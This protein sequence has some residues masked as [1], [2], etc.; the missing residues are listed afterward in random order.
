MNGLIGMLENQK[1]NGYLILR[2]ITG[3]LLA[4][5]GYQKMFGF[6][7]DGVAGF[8]GSVGLPAAGILAILVTLLELVGG[9]AILLGVFTRLLGLWMVVQFGLIA[10]WVKPMLMGKGF[11]GDGG[12]EIDLLLFGIGILL[13]VRGSRKLS[14]SGMLLKNARWAE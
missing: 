6:G 9:I 7:I 3:A 5:H 13:A 14:L 11:S 12:W 10:V 2:V 8:F 4:F 1:A